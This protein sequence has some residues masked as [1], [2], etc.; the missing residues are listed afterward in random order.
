[1]TPRSV[2]NSNP[3]NLR[4]GEPWQGLMPADQMTPEQRA[5]TSFAVFKEPKWGFRALAIL[6]RNYHTM[7]GLSTVRQIINRFAPT[8]ENDTNSYINHVAEQIGVAPD[9][10]IDSSRRIISFHL[11][12]AIAKHETGSWEPYWTDTCLADGLD[13]AGL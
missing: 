9:D 10:K 13:L 3:G 11:C 6:L 4:K 8:N 1:M 5:E 2:R 12:K 7:Y